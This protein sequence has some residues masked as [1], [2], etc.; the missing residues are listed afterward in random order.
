MRLADQVST[1]GRTQCLRV[2]GD[3]NG[4]A[5][6]PFE[7]VLRVT[8]LD[9]PHL[10][11]QPQVLAD[12]SG[13]SGWPDLVDVER[14]IVVEAD[15]FEFHGRRKALIRDCERYNALVLRGWT[16]LRF[17]W[18]HVMFEPE[19]VRACLSRAGPRRPPRRAAS[20]RPARR[21]A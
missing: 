15:F 7:S 2:A 20:R 8:A 5:A 21:T 17:S 4:R 12:E 18:E 6:N 13:W 1:T 9:V 10:D 3:A 16:V 19:Y 11:L 14:R